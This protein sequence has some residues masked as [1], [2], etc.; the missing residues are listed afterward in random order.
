M[1]LSPPITMLVIVVGAFAWLAVT[2]PGDNCS[3]TPDG[4]LRHRSIKEAFGDAFKNSRDC[5]VWQGIKPRKAIE[6]VELNEE[7][8]GGAMIV[9]RIAPNGSGFVAVVPPFDRMN[10]ALWKSDN[11]TLD[12][13]RKYAPTFEMYP[14]S[15]SLYSS[16]IENIG[17]MRDFQG[18]IM[19]E[20]S[21]RESLKYSELDNPLT[22]KI[23]CKKPKHSLPIQTGPV[24][25][26]R[27]ADRDQP[28]YVD[29]GGNCEDN[30]QLKA[31]LRVSIS[32]DLM[33]QAT[34]HARE[35]HALGMH[36]FS[37]CGAVRSNQ[38]C[39]MPTL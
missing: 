8:S 27:F 34:G 3:Y 9:A 29:T 21:S 2:K 28:V 6:T 5:D 39:V 7:T 17:P 31:R 32:L 22:R 33:I 12:Q 10:H 4:K 20:L 25:T 35:I 38:P 1:R 14:R 11:P 16:I 23:V 37:Y 19:L 26:F 24:V 15:Q 36:Q 18:G 13:F 30:A